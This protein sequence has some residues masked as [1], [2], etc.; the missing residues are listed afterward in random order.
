M[1]TDKKKKE[2]S[3]ENKTELSKTFPWINTLGNYFAIVT[4]FLFM[5]IVLLVLVCLN[6]LVFSWF[7]TLGKIA[8]SNILF[9]L[10][11]IGTILGI[12]FIFAKVTG[13]LK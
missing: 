13:W 7:L 10:I 6:L 2:S 3:S 4:M 11:Y 8:I 12:I 5:I 1:T 9:F